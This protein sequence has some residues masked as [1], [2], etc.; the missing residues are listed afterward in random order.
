MNK[1]HKYIQN[2]NEDF[3]NENR[4]TGTWVILKINNCNTNN[5]YEYFK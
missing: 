3:E 5:G 4:T 2:K 1:C